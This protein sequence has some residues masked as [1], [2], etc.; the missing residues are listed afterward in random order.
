MSGDQRYDDVRI[1]NAIDGSVIEGHEAV[2]A[3]FKRERALTD[4]HGSTVTFQ[5]YRL[6]L[7]GE[8]LE[9]MQG[10]RLAEF[11][12]DGGDIGGDERVD[13]VE[14]RIR[15]RLQ[16]KLGSLQ[17]ITLWFGGRPMR[18]GRLFYADHPMMLPSWVQVLIHEHP[19]A[20]VLEAMQRLD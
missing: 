1:V 2:A 10:P 12:I 15:S 13:D 20:D 4:A 18:P 16:D 6:D 19:L 8:T 7:D 11:T 14:V 5:V 17:H 9:V 3:H